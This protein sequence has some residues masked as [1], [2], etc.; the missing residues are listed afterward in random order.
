MSKRLIIEGGRVID[1]ALGL[2]E[3]RSVVVERGQVVALPKRAPR[4]KTARVVD[5]R[6]RWVLP[7]FIDLHVH[8][9]EP[10]HE[11][12]ETIATGTRAAV[13]GG[14]TSVVAMPNT[15]PVNDSVA[16][17]EFILERARAARLARVYPAGA[18]TR[19]L[20][21]EELSE[22]GDL[23][24]AG[25]VVFTDDGMPIMRAGLMRRALEYALGL[26]V[27]IMVHEEDHT[28]SR[29][30]AMHEGEVSTRLGLP[31]IP[32][33]AEDVMVVRDIE[34]A[35]YTGARLHVA[36]LS[37]AGAVRA[38]RA[39]KA[40]GVAVTCEITPHHFTFTDEA[41]C[42]YDP[43]TKMMPPL[44]SAEDRE[45]CIEAL[46]DGTA[47]AI[48]TDHAPHSLVEKDVEYDRAANGVVGLETAFSATLALVREGRLGLHRAIE[49]LT[50]G[51]ARVLGLPGGT[52]AEGAPAD[53]VMVDPEAT[54]TVDPSK[55][56][57]KSRN[58]PFK[59]MTLPG[60]VEMTWVGGR[61][62]HALPAKERR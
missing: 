20:A 59:G 13:A 48:A 56:H 6:G 15:Q 11:Y 38:V 41:V 37:T 49:L 32:A 47:D 55:F 58:T 18:V 36:H 17:T 51:P 25:C 9:R 29:G 53:L 33:A 26:G 27:P 34:L 50:S 35:E 62:V 24:R 10:G 44:R 8:L 52:L 1:P 45:A 19:G 21:G 14:F 3:V 30:G 4:R 16:V 61:R 42:G 28:L 22:M 57:S 40:R 39:A 2:D 60:R 46:A 23:H 5:A 12:K 54:W 7:G 43:D 31:G